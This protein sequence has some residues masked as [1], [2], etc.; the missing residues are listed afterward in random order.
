MNQSKFVRIAKKADNNITEIIATYNEHSSSIDLKQN[1][2]NSKS[3]IHHA[4]INNNIDLLCWLVLQNCDVNSKTN[5]NST[6]LH[7]AVAKKSKFWCDVRA[8]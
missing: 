1:D 4:G 6:P 3:L 2:G 8:G 5:N 7:F